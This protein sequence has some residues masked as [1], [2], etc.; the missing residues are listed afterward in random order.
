PWSTEAALGPLIPAGLVQP[1]M[2]LPFLPGER[3]SLTGG[4][5]AAW[6]SGTPRGAL[7]FSPITGE[8]VCA[9][10]SRWAVAVAPGVIVRSANNALALDLDGDGDEQTG[11]VVV[12]YHLAEADM[13]SQDSLV[14]Q[15]EHLGHP[16]CE[17]GHSTGKH[18]HVVRKYNGEWLPADGPLPFVLSGW[19]AVAGSRNYE[20]S[21]VRD[22]SVVS[23]NPGGNQ[24]SVI[25]R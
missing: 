10:S 9:V 2:E 6:D 7:D 18:V 13:I 3:W 17:G 23:S 19:K 15:D 4:P 24:S 22:G 21:L 8:A 20:G 5:H 25:Y 12:Y 16:S 11:W 1:E 14:A